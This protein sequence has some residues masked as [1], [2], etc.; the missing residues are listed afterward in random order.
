MGIKFFL[1]NI[2]T[3]INVIIFRSKYDL[4]IFSHV[5]QCGG[6]TILH[7]FKF[8]LGYRFININR[9][10]IEFLKK[11]PKILKKKLKGEILVLGHFGFD[12]VNEISKIY[13]KKRI[14][15]LLNIRNPK[16]RYLSNYYRNKKINKIKI[17][18]KD[19]L[20]LR[21]KQKLDNLF[22]RFLSGRSIYHPGTSKINKKIFHVALKNLKKF[23]QVIL[24]ENLNKGIFILIRNL[25]FF[26][27]LSRLIK[28][29]KNRVSGSKY[30]KISKSENKIVNKLIKYD[31][32][33]YLYAEK[34]FSNTRT[35]I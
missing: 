28:F 19:F 23:D 3:F 35:T 11:N 6:N 31:R 15:L 10:D 9:R 24:L 14:F 26:S 12:F 13:N 33:I 7:T 25:F 16:N 22:V 34:K 30:K 20:M 4:I 17:N 1:V 29:H 18:L 27:F 8:F 2:L 5:P 32:L 21:H